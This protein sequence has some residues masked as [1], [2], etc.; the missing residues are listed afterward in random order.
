MRNILFCLLF[1]AAWLPAQVVRVANLSPV[2][3]DGWKRTT[4]DVLPP[5]ERCEK[6]GVTAVLG[7]RIGLD[8]WALD[9]LVSLQ[10]GET[11]TV[12]LATAQPSSWSPAPVPGDLNAFF[13]GM[14]ALNGAPMPLVGLRPDG[15]AWI[16]H[17]QVRTGRMFVVDLW[18]TL[19]P[20]RPYYAL[21][22]ALVTCSNP[23]VPDMGEAVGALRLTFGDA[24][25]VAPGGGPGLLAPGLRFADGQ[26]RALPCSFVWLRHLR[27]SQD[28]STAGAAAHL[29]IGAVGIRSLLPGGNPTLQRG[30]NVSSWV[31]QHWFR[32]LG[33][34]ATW[35]HPVL[36]PAADTGQTGA[37]EDQTFVGAECFVPGGVGAE[38]VNW[39]AA[40]QTSGHP[41]HHLELDG[42][43]VDAARRPNL[44][45]FYSRPHSSGSDRLNK[46]RDLTLVE[47]NG[48]NGPDAQHWTTNRLFAACRTVPTFAGQRLLEHHA[49][50]YI[51][52]LTDVPGWSTS[53]LWSTRELLWEGLLVRNCWYGLE[54]RGLAQRVLDRAKSRLVRIVVP[55]WS[56]KDI[57]DI[58][59]DDARL[60]SGAWWMPWQEAAGAYGADVLGELTGVPE[61]RAVALAGAKRILAD[62]WVREGDRWVEYELQA[63]DGRRSRSGYFT[64][65]W[66]PLAV[67]VVLRHEPANE[68]ARSIW[69]QIVAD[70]DGN[71]RW[72]PPEVR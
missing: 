43:V 25:V 17:W 4:V 34:L 32:T 40:L 29:Q 31:G 56:G 65:A 35:E 42:S 52:Q 15:A 66:L 9:V 45:M 23:S 48:W 1:V 14:P 53:E 12:D 67:A 22:E 6:D 63:L 69:A 20:D 27:T 68:Q 47:A 7:R 61:A 37:V 46:P 18:A 49:R 30:F 10:P 59:I 13:G 3:F 71:G 62:A 38:Q 5:H 60:G 54:D 28:W 51:V 8:V 72:L 58:R 33:A 39:Y 50:N 55:K 70:A 21:G 24:A 19:N 16:A 2:P 11:K 41:M 57:R 64:A 36:G 26:A 44:R